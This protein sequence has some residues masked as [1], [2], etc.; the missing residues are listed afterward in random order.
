MFNRVNCLILY[1]KRYL[2]LS[3]VNYLIL[4]FILFLELEDVLQYTG[5]KI[6]ILFSALF[7]IFVYNNYNNDLESSL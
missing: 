4:F 7:L 2:I 5:I 1:S 6:L 3:I